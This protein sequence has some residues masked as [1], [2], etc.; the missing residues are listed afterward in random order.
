MEIES[1]W[2]V[3][4]DIQEGTFQIDQSFGE[5]YGTGAKSDLW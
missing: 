5:P 1:I 4:F 2:L 3:E